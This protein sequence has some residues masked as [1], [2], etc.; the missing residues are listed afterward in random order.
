MSQPRKPDQQIVDAFVASLREHGHPGLRVDRRPDEENR[1]A[2]DI[3]PIAGPFAIEHTSVDTV[4]NQRQASAH[5][6]HV[7]GG[8]REEL[9]GKVPFRLRITVQWSA[10]RKGQDWAA[11]R[12][13]LKAW[14]L[15]E[16]PSLVDGRHVIDDDAIPGVPFGLLVRKA[17]A[18][19]PGIIFGR[20]EPHDAAF[21]ARIRKQLD[22][23]AA[24]LAKYRPEKTTILLVE[25]ND[26]A[27]MNES[28]LLGA[29]KG[30]YSHALPPGVDQVWY[31]D[32]SVP[33]GEVVFMDFTPDLCG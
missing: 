30:A 4:A 9:A 1:R 31:A 5:F 33:E 27:L 23:K 20:T 26:I 28:I 12:Q 8:I 18:R 10:V 16:S 11:I 17:S 14:I 3:D 29:I 19:P 7:V 22:E 25:S 32:T 21:P 6:G 24:K 2:R 13:V 15:A